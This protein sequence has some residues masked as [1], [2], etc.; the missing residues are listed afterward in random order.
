MHKGFCSSVQRTGDVYMNLP[1]IFNHLGLVR[2]ER[3]WSTMGVNPDENGIAPPGSN[4]S[5]GGGNKTTGDFG[6]K[7]RI[8]D[9]VNV[10]AAI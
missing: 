1:L 10:Q 4:R 8:G 7:G 2:R 9:S 6:V 3:R 5:S